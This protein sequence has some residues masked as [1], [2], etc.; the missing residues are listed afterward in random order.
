MIYE[1]FSNEEI[2]KAI[3]IEIKDEEIEKSEFTA[4]GYRMP[5]DTII[6]S[7]G[8]FVNYAYI[9]DSDIFEADKVS[10]VKTK[11]REMAKEINIHYNLES[12]Y[13][14]YSSRVLRIEHQKIS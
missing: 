6:Y 9:L 13:N 10:E 4:I 3:K 11:L 12:T 14:I 5:N 7:V 2:I 1:Y 8:L